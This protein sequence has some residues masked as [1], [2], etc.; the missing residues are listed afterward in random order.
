MIELKCSSDHKAL[1]TDMIPFQG[2]SKKRTDQDIDELSTTLKEDGLLQPLSMW[3]A[4][5]EKLYILDGH[6]RLA[7]LT[8]L[9][10][11]D[12]SILQQEFPI[13]LVIAQTH[14]EAI[15][16][17][18]QMMSQCGKINKAGVVKFAQPVI[19]YKA[20][21][22][23]KAMVTPVHI[24]KDE[25]SSDKVIVKMRVDKSKVSELISILSKVTGVEVCL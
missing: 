7:A 24:K 16:A 3:H 11:S 18:L 22:V 19:N 5:D 4:P 14:E 13:N 23:T 10:L 9:A 21:I 12:P 25:A 6:G 8:K 2:E 15:K 17:C 20:P 1:L